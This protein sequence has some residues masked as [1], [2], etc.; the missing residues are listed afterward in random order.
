MHICMYVRTAYSY[1]HAYEY[2]FPHVYIQTYI[3]T[4]IHVCIYTHVYASPFGKLPRAPSNQCHK[5]DLYLHPLRASPYIKDS[6][7]P[8]TCLEVLKATKNPL[9]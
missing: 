6:Q 9:E 8:S 1:V 4:H 5:Q 2:M 3:Y 7:D